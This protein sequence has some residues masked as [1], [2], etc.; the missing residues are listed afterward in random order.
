MRIVGYVGI[1]VLIIGLAVAA[2][3]YT[4]RTD[5]P[6][7]GDCVQ[8][9]GNGGSVAVSCS[10]SGAFKVTHSVTKVSDCP[11]YL[12]EPSLHYTKGSTTVILCLE[13]VS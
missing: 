1:V 7:V 5:P 2:L 3:V 8:Q 12:N 4:S 13:P 9:S 11:D 10:T 6:K